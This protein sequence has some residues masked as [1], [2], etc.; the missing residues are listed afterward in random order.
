MRKKGEQKERP[1]PVLVFSLYRSLLLKSLKLGEGLLPRH[2]R[3]LFSYTLGKKMKEK[4]S[5]KGR[6]ARKCGAPV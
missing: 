5:K 6:K 2:S 3:F 4:K 1:F